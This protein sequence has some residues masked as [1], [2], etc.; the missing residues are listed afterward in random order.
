MQQEN[1]DVM[2]GGSR[3]GSQYSRR[4]KALNDSNEN[5]EAPAE[6]TINNPQ[7]FASSTKKMQQLEGG[8]QDGDLK[9]L[10][11]HMEDEVDPEKKL[12]KEM[13][14]KADEQDKKKEEAVKQAL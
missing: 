8:E 3:H 10:L 7:A 12:L 2:V 11:D 5:I 1:N 14:A 6:A 13:T 9:G 4:N